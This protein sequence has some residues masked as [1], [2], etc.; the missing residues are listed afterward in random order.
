MLQ[1]PQLLHPLHHNPAATLP[2]KPR[3]PHEGLRL[4]QGSPVSGSS[5]MWRRAE[6]YLTGGGNSTLFSTPSMSAS[7]TLM[8]KN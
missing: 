2:G 8:S 1:V 6:G 4:T 5:P 7:M 3:N